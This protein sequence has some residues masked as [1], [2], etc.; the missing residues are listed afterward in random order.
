MDAFG[1]RH[2]YRAGDTIVREGEKGDEL[3]IIRSGKVRI[4]KGKGPDSVTLAVL[5]QGEYLGEMA[6]LGEYPR[7]AS[8]TAETDVDVTVIDRMTFR[9]FVSDPIVFDIMH[10]MA[11]RI[12]DLDECVVEAQQ[13]EEARRA[14]LASSMEQRHWFV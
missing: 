5:N 3:F 13:S 7:S 1:T 4:F 6:L 14:F 9:A 11:D 10:K 2:R 12:R 8:A